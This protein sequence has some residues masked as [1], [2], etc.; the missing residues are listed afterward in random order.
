MRI[1][2]MMKIFWEKKYDC[3]DREIH[4]HS[5]SV[6]SS[7][8]MEL[9]GGKILT[10]LLHALLPP[11]TM[12]ARTSASHPLYSEEPR[13]AGG[14]QRCIIAST[15]GHSTFAMAVH[16]RAQPCHYCAITVHDHS[17]DR[18]QSDIAVHLPCVHVVYRAIK[19]TVAMIYPKYFDKYV[20]NSGDD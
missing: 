14:S 6:F 3:K 5:L 20:V 12:S 1:I 15:Y 8:I 17:V 16:N 2:R 18:V 9:S 7:W 13:L 10:F 4:A 19:F 11:T